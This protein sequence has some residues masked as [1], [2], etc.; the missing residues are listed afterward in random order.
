M[1]DECPGART[2]GCKSFR[3]ERFICDCDRRSRH[4]QRGG[5]FPRGGQP[6]S[7]PKAPVQNGLPDLPI[8]LAAKVI[9]INKTDMKSHNPEPALFRIGLVTLLK[10][11]GSILPLDGLVN[12]IAGLP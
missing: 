1:A 7:R 9:P 4:G 10:G 12:R 8:Y 6:L 2:R 11:E 5:Q 3:D